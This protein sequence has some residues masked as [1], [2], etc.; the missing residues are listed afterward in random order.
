MG[1]TDFS[2]QIDEFIFETW[3]LHSIGCNCIAGPSAL[4]PQARMKA[5]I[6]THTHT[7]PLSL[8]NFQALPPRR[9]FQCSQDKGIDKIHL[10]GV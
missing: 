8:T 6:T 1:N 9:C 10:T 2:F 3:S 5:C 4:L 7:F